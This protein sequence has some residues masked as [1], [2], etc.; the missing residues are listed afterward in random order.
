[1]RRSPASDIPARFEGRVDLLGFSSL[2]RR[3]TR[4]CVVFYRRDYP[5][6]SAFP[7]SLAGFR[8]QDNLTQPAES[9]IWVGSRI[10]VRLS[11]WANQG[12]LETTMNQHRKK[13]GAVSYLNTKPLVA[14]LEAVGERYELI[15]DLPSRLADRLASGEL[16][17]ALI[18]SVEAT[19]NPDY[20]IV[21]DACIGCCGPVWSVKL[22]SKVPPQQIKTLA[23]D[24]GSRTSRALTRVILANKYDCRPELSNLSMEDDWR[25]AKTDAVL[26]IGDR[27]MKLDGG[28]FE[29]QWDLGEAWNQWTGL[30]FVF[31]MWVAREEDQLDFLSGL[32]S[33]ARDRGLQQLDHLVSENHTPYG[34]S[35][36]QC[37][38]YLKNRL[39]FWLGAEEKKALS[40]FFDYASKLSIVP[41]DTELEFHDCQT[42]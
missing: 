36:E 5:E 39:H 35:R 7:E 32:L 3:S 38:D 12:L 2:N 13:I 31:A 24:E 4:L 19:L 18:P 42:A 20:R 23:L 28:S 29:H 25:D 15:F 1:M 21:S 14:G 30:P 26:V 17:V 6:E 9:R 10:G 33:D 34:L 41:Q 37:E 27:A 22:L 11:C 16:D 8:S 40:L